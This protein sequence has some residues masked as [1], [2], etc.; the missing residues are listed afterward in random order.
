MKKNRV[1]SLCG[2]FVSLI[3]VGLFGISCTSQP[4]NEPTKLT[5]GKVTKLVTSYMKENQISQAF[6]KF[7]VGRFRCD[8]KATREMYR[9]LEAA[10]VITLK[11]DTTVVSRTVKTGTNYWTGKAEYSTKK[12]TIYT[13]TTSLAGDTQSYLVENNPFKKTTDPDMEQPEIGDYPE[14]H[15]DEVVFDT[16]DVQEG[17][18]A[19]KTVYAKGTS[20]SLVKVRNIRISQKSKDCAWFE[21]ILQNGQVTP[22]Y[23]VIKRSYDNEKKLFHGK[24][25]YYVDKGW[26]IVGFSDK[27]LEEDAS[28]ALVDLL[29]LFAD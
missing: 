13:L 21:C 14:F 4:T 24:L 22:A 16:P 27:D 28:S 7:S 5:E 20:V 26:T 3:I 15:L 18:E 11:I 9:K 6:T 19:F 8:D 12:Q 29:S 1:T 23:R 17:E 10:G 25:Q 2:V